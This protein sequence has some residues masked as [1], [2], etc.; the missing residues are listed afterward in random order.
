M[1]PSAGAWADTLAARGPY[2]T[3][4]FAAAPLAALIEVLPAAAAG[5]PPATAAPSFASRADGKRPTPT[6]PPTKIA[7]AA[8]KAAA[9]SPLYIF[10]RLGVPAAA[11]PPP[12][13]S[14]DTLAAA[15]SAYAALGSTPWQGVE[16]QREISQ[17]SAA[18]LRYATMA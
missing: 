5:A 8:Q 11:P 7:A 18:L 13:P 12:P 10:A 2:T 1:T 16:P 15:L 14:A 4:S 9:A 17:E 3:L 6:P